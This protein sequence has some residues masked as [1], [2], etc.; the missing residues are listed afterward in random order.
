[1]TVALRKPLS[2]LMVRNL[3]NKLVLGSRDGNDLTFK[4]DLFDFVRQ[5]LH[6]FLTFGAAS[7]AKCLWHFLRGSEGSLCFGEVIA[8]STKAFAANH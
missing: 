3:A 1:M 4:Q 2:H 5:A 8:K 7:A 6:P